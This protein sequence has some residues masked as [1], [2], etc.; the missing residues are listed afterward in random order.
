[1]LTKIEEGNKTIEVLIDQEKKEHKTIEELLKEKVQ[2]PLGMEIAISE[3]VDVQEGTTSDTISRKDGKLFASVSA[4]ITTKDV[5]KA[6]TAIQKKVDELKYPIK[7][8]S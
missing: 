4:E 5:A 3:L 7:C 8:N 2:S 1:M 6:S